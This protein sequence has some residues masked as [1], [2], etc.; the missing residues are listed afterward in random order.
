M[1]RLKVRQIPFRFDET[2]PYYWNSGNPYWGNVVNFISIIGPA[3][4]RYFIKAIRQAMPLIKDPLIQEDAELFCLQEGQHSKQHL[5]HL[6]ALIKQHPGLVETRRRV[7]DSYEQL[8]ATRSLEFHLAYAATIELTF[9]PIAKFM[10]ENREVLFAD[11]DNRVA[12]LVLWHFVEEFEHRNSAND[13]YQHI[14]G[15]YTWRMRMAVD[16][17]RHIREVE[18]MTRTGLRA[19]VPPL[20]WGEILVTS[21]D[22]SGMFHNIPLMNLLDFGW[23]LLCSQMPL[24]KPDRLRQPEW[25]TRWFADESAGKDMSVYVP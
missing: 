7:M 12:A 25:V 14:V 13:V 15:S 23:H 11:C 2:T 22:E 16:V 8:F 6:Q 24:H 1:S 19:H 5:L 3:F 9:G 10:V 20:Q 17:Y 21:D 4:E 18:Q